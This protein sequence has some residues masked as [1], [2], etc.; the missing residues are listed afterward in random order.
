MIHV[1]EE[2]HKVIIHPCWHSQRKRWVMD[3]PLLILQHSRTESLHPVNSGGAD[4][5][6]QT[7]SEHGVAGSQCQNQ[8]RVQNKKSGSQPSL[9]PQYFSSVSPSPT[10]TLC[11]CISG[12][13][14]A[15]AHAY[16]H[17]PH[18]AEASFSTI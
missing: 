18:I 11:S 14:A 10:L 7:G 6:H 17:L 12:T 15:H 13:L 9:P 1:F 3:T 5:A 16:V 4:F 8:L 2:W